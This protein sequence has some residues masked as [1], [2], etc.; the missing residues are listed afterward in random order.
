MLLKIISQQYFFYLGLLIKIPLILFVGSEVIETLFIPFL[1]LSLTNI[2]KNPWSIL[3]ANH[4]PYGSFLLAV[5]W[6]PIKILS[7]VVNIQTLLNS[8]LLLIFIKSILL[9]FDTLLF[10]VLNLFDKGIYRKQIII[11]YWLNPIAIYICY[12]HGQLDIV[13]ITLV[14]IS[15]YFLIKNRIILFSLAFSASILSKFTSVIIFPFL[16]AYI[17][18]QN[19]IKQAILKIA[20]SVSSVSLFVIIGFLP[21]FNS[22]KLGYATFT[23][24]QALQVFS[25]HE[26]LSGNLSVFLGVLFLLIAMERLCLATKIT[27]KGLL[28]GCSYLFLIILCITVPSPGWFMWIIPFVALFYANYRMMPYPIY[29]ALIVSYFIHFCIGTF[30]TTFWASLSLTVLIT[31]T[32]SLIALLELVC[33]KYEVTLFGRLKP[34]K[35]A[36]AGDSGSGKNFLTSL[37]VGIFNP[38]RTIVIEG[39]DYHKWE[40]GDQSWQKMTHLDPKANHLNTLATHLKSIAQ[41]VPIQYHHYDHQTGKFTETKEITPSKTVI[42]QGLHTL[43]LKSTRESAKLKIFLNPDFRIRLAWKIKRD[44]KERGYTPEKVLDQLLKREKDSLAYIEPQQEFADWILGYKPLDDNLT[45][46]DILKGDEIQI[47]VEHIF[48]YDFY[49]EDIMD[50]LKT[51]ASCNVY[52]EAEQ[53]LGFKKS[54]K[55]EGAPTQ[56]EIEYL[57]HKFFPNLRHITRGWFEPKWMGGYDGINQLIFLRMLEETKG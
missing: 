57:A 12:I 48:W 25:L 40:R 1:E 15:I 45:K 26:S 34:F 44:V 33:L 50:G 47:L 4:F 54:V 27:E 19:F 41:G 9:G 2:S 43:F 23:S 30:L 6:L 32:V 56:Q 49:I 18:N 20:K 8:K 7:L 31:L 28:F 5:F 55:I 29:I 51:I 17:W 52:I 42:Y 36:I 35:I 13:F 24:P 37:I 3:P 46:E 14:I 39:D 16:L 53:N 21:L 10:Y 38:S 11:F 22:G